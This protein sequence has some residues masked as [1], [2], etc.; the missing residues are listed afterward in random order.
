M[1]KQGLLASFA[2]LATCIA[3][4]QAQPDEYCR[5]LAPKMESNKLYVATCLNGPS[6]L[7]TVVSSAGGAVLQGS[8]G[9]QHQLNPGQN[10]RF[11]LKT[12]TDGTNVNSLVVIQVKRLDATSRGAP[13]PVRLRR[14]PLDFA[15]VGFNRGGASV[16]EWPP[17]EVH[18]RN[19]PSVPYD[20]YDQFHRYGF[21]TPDETD[22]LRQFHVSY[23]NGQSCVSTT[24]PIRRAQFLFTDRQD[25]HGYVVSAVT[26][27]GIFATE[28]NAQSLETMSKYEDLKV[29]L[30]NYRRPPN[31][32]GCFSFSTR[33][34]AVKS[35]RL[36][37]TISDIEQQVRTAPF[38]SSQSWSFDLQ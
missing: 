25:Y 13:A 32:A 34:G 20:K 1:Y 3:S 22:R 12:A 15:C 33:A 8:D 29:L 21:T 26:R 4:A 35:V 24:D 38:D 18:G 37:L 16:P 23:F 19:L 17:S 7:S 6:C 11:L 31:T 36:D 2:A 14:Y 10:Y 27:F 30:G 9:Q 28:A 5:L